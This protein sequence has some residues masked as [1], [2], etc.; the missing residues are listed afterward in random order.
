[1]HTNS[2]VQFICTQLY[3]DTL[4]WWNQTI[5]KPLP[6]SY[7]FSPQMHGRTSE[8][9]SFCTLQSVF[10]SQMIF[11]TVT[12]ASVPP[13]VQASVV[14]KRDVWQDSQPEKISMPVS[15]IIEESRLTTWRLVRGRR[16][17]KLSSWHK[18]TIEKWAGQTIHVAGE[19][20]WRS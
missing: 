5:N 7:W 11:H 9:D 2:N 14:E 1:M 6:Y 12:A 18:N 19:W 4:N 3:W 20:N 13:T 17:S 15:P 8:S 10:N 16:R